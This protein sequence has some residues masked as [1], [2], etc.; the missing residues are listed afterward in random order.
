MLSAAGRLE[1][2]PHRPVRS[3]A[4]STNAANRA[5]LQGPAAG[6][7]TAG[8]SLQHLQQQ[9]THAVPAA[10]APVQAGSEQPA[11]GGELAA[12]QTAVNELALSMSGAE[13]DA[14]YASACCATAILLRRNVQAGSS[15][16]VAVRSGLLEMYQAVAAGNAPPAGV[17]K[18][19]LAQ[20]REAAAGCSS[21]IAINLPAEAAVVQSS[22]QQVASSSNK[23]QNEV[24]AVASSRKKRKQPAAHQCDPPADADKRP[25]LWLT[26]GFYAQL[27]DTVIQQVE[28]AARDPCT[29]NVYSSEGEVASAWVWRLEAFTV[30]SVTGRFYFNKERSLNEPLNFQ[31]SR[32]QKLPRPAGVAGVVYTMEPD[33]EGDVS[34]VLQQLDPAVVAEVKELLFA[35]VDSDSETE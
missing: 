21:S 17:L 2:E 35:P 6:S 13:A 27:G 10:V 32:V 7:G 29:F 28:K 14:A 34:E 24:A 4:A 1:Y 3:C 11:A 22:G 30:D 19:L 23:R 9:E 18:Q 8:A 15:R 20:L 16:A 25:G 12:A 5:L 33:V 26:G 31:H